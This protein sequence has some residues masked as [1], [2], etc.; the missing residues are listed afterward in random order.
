MIRL[1]ILYGAIL[2]IQRITPNRGRESCNWWCL[3]NVTYAIHYAFVEVK[4]IGIWASIKKQVSLFIFLFI[5][6]Y[7]F[8]KD[9]TKVHAKCSRI[10]PNYQSGLVLRWDSSD[11]ASP[12]LC[13]LIL[14]TKGSLKNSQKRKAFRKHQPSILPPLYGF[15]YS[16]LAWWLSNTQIL[17]VYGKS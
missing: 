10:W 16:P 6:M 12:M 3:S 14:H 13:E 15:K 9:G 2:Y 5:I 8:A 17:F 11:Q 1:K 4:A 7:V